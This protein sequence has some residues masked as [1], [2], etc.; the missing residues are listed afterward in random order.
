LLIPSEK[1]HFDFGSIEV[2]ASGLSALVGKPAPELKVKTRSGEELLLSNMRG[3]IVV[4]DFWGHWCVPCV[5]AMPRLME[6]AEQ[7][8][9][10]PVR[11][12]AVHDASLTSFKDLDDKLSKFEKDVWNREMSLETVIDVATEPDDRTG[13]TADRYG[14]RNWPTLVVIS[15]DGIVVGPTTK[16]ALPKELE[17]LLAESR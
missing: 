6:I 5:R 17:E 3:N 10:R 11:W 1:R 9:G 4:L 12:I 7:F 16:V 15:A 13:G 2:E 14:V 8:E